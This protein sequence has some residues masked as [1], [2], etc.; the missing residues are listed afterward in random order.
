MWIIPLAVTLIAGLLRFINL[1]HP[2]MLIFD[3]TYYVKD[4]YSMLQSG[5]E[6]EWKKTS[7][8]S[9]SPAIRG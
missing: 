6:R 2:H 1:S 3:E 5:Y 8:S 9:S 7:T 4:A